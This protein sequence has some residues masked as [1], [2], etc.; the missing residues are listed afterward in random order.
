MRKKKKNKIQKNKNKIELRIWKTILLLYT[1]QKVGNS[2]LG[3][4]NKIEYFFAVL[5]TKE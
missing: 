4:S 1:R 5:R 2:I 3:P